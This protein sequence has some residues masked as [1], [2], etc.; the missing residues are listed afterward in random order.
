M[1]RFLDA[2]FRW[3]DNSDYVALIEY[4]NS[5][6]IFRAT[7]AMRYSCSLDSL[8]SKAQSRLQILIERA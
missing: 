8:I 1:E 4:S 3:H 6:F 2:S 7:F 5:K